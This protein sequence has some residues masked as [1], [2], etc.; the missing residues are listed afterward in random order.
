MGNALNHIINT[1]D[2]L[3]SGH[4]KTESSSEGTTV[5]DVAAALKHTITSSTQDGSQSF[6]PAGWLRLPEPAS[7]AKYVCSSQE[8]FE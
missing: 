4:P 5:K 1:K 3:S 8:G 7:L 6:S 2:V